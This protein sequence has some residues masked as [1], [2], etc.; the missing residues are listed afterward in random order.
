MGIQA[1]KAKGLAIIR[2]IRNDNPRLVPSKLRTIFEERIARYSPAQ[3]VNMRL[4]LAPRFE[5][6]RKRNVG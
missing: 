4:A 3:K 1:D 6:R 2:Q 5:T